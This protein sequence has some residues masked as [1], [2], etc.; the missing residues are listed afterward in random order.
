[1][2]GVTLERIAY[3]PLMR[4]GVHRL[5]VVITALMC[6]LVLENGN[7]ALLGAS[8]RT[9]PDLLDKK[10]YV[11]SGITVTNIKLYVIFAALLVFLLLQFVVTRTRVGMAMRAVSYN[12]FALPLMGVPMSSV[13][14]F[15][16]ILGSGVAGLGGMLFAMSYPVLE[17]YMGAMTGWK[18]FIA[19]VVGGI[20]DVRG[21]FLGGFLLAFVEIMVTA[22]LPST[23]RD[24]FAFSILLLILWK[25]PTGIFGLPLTAKI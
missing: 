18:A 3:R 4:K 2:C 15:T 7:L 5:Y 22:F 10:V 9:L 20:G 23:F 11:F 16:F 19:A 25:R 13:I 8:R 17:P 12:K 24:L 6:G 21:A 14:V 1:M